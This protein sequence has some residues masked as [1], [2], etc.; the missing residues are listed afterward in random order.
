MGKALIDLKLAMLKRDG[1]VRGT[2]ERIRRNGGKMTL[3]RLY[4]ITE[5]ST[6]PRQADRTLLA[7]YLQ[8]P[9]RELF[10]PEK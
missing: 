7:Q 4:R 10:P 8:L 2:H 6:P 3:S 1:S 9:A 5:G